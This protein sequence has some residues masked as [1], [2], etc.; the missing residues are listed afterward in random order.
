[1]TDP[2]YA[3]NILDGLLGSL[4]YI[5]DEKQ[6]FNLYD[7]L[8]KRFKNYNVE[9]SDDG[10]IVF[11]TMV[12]IFGDHGTSPRTGWFYDKDI[13]DHCVKYLIDLMNNI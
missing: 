10:N 2:K 4:S 11:G 8:V 6:L 3:V 13:P 5:R 12:M 1:M 9:F 7:E